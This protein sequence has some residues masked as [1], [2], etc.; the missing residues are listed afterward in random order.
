M[1]AASLK[2]PNGPRPVYIKPIQT[3][4]T[5][6][7][8]GDAGFV[9]KH[10]PHVATLCLHSWAMPVSP[11]LAARLEQHNPH[12]ATICLHSWATCP[13][14]LIW[15][16]G[17]S[18][19]EQVSRVLITSFCRPV[20]LL[21]LTIPFCPQSCLI[22]PHYSLFVLS[23]ALLLLSIPFCPHYCLI[24]PQYS[25]FVLSIALLVLSIALFSSI[26]PYCYSELPFCPQYCFLLLR[27]AFLL[28]SIPFLLLSIAFLLLSIAF[29]SSVLPFSA[30]IAVVLPFCSA[31]SLSDDELMKSVHQAL[32]RHRH[33]PFILLETAG[34]VLSPTPA[35][36]LQADAYRAL[37]LPIVLVGDGRLGGISATLSAL[38]SLRI[39]GYDIAA[40]VVCDDEPHLDNA[41]AIRT[42]VSA[43]FPRDGPAVLSLPRVPPMPEPLDHWLDNA[44]FNQLYQ[45]LLDE[46]AARLRALNGLAGRAS[47]CIWWPFTQHTGLRAP[48][49]VDSAYADHYSIYEQEAQSVRAR[50]DAPSSWWTQGVGHGNSQMA[51]SI[52]AAAGRY[53]HVMFPS[54]AHEPAVDLAEK[55]LAK[56]GKDWAAKVFYS[57]DGSTAMEV[58]LKMAFRLYETRGLRRDKTKP[59]G[60]LAQAGCYH[61]DTLGVMNVAERS[62][63]N[64]GQHPWFKSSGVFLTPPVL[65]LRKG[66]W[67]VGDTPFAHKAAAYDFDARQG[68]KLE[69][70]YAQS[71]AQAFAT[72]SMEL[73]AVCIE[74]V[75][76]GAGGMIL[77]DPLYQ[78][79]LIK[80]A[81]RRG[82]PVIYDE[83]F[84]GCFRLGAVG[85]GSSWLLER[86]DVACFAKLLTGG[87]VPLAVT[88]A[89]QE[90]FDAFL[91][92]KMSQTLLHGHS[93]TAYP[94]GCAAA[95]TA[96][97]MYEEVLGD[98]DCKE[99]MDA[100][101]DEGLVRELSRL[102]NVERAFR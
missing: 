37:R 34:G 6:S 3:G 82:V 16:P 1:R 44:P 18:G 12:V 31:R 41:Q 86:P 8:G 51:Q 48:M 29:C 91:G 81:K 33:A 54:I 67:W 25:L 90:T 70:E 59:L 28:L 19:L 99:L 94:V 61:G 56:A 84:S 26:L 45:L 13:S 36:S 83:V 64:E 87:A 78:K 100:F 32:T 75:L 14:R 93:F 57:D 71:I 50:V 88:L 85:A 20:A 80:E 49:V 76:M 58:A 15:R 60:V 24:A 63:F 4:A 42:H 10:N 79:I 30:R 73:G 62:V 74:P 40:V 89:S 27:M 97:D 77:V 98:R 23:I 95:S 46:H 39:R 7:S 52:A 96:L 92:S 68:S 102:P 21:L 22:A 101:W 5:S 66:E 69:A 9:R 35:M 72:S 43:I 17:S 2:F 38:E 53:G 47:E 65:S 55:I 11:H